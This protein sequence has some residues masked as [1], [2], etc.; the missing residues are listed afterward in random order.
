MLVVRYRKEEHKGKDGGQGIVS[1]SVG[2]E[3]KED[4]NRISKLCFLDF[5]SLM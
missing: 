4:M 5:L 3:M 2:C 1:E